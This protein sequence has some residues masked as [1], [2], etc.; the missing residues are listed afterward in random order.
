MKSGSSNVSTAYL[1]GIRSRD[2]LKTSR[3]GPSRDH[4]TV[5]CET[6]H[7]VSLGTSVNRAVA[8]SVDSGSAEAYTA[9]LQQN[10]KTPSPR[11]APGG[12]GP[13]SD[14]TG[15]RG[16]SPA[17]AGVGLFSFGP[18]PTANPAGAEE[19]GTTVSEERLFWTRS[20]LGLP[21]ISEGA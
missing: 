13:T 20:S 8:G 18:N 9:K 2:E 11:V 6:F 21:Q 19:G 3:L 12:G 5:V 4:A 15:P 1:A 16:E 17:N 10:A 7:T 14:L